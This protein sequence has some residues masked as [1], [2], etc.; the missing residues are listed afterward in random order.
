MARIAALAL[1]L[2][3]A[4]T[5]CTGSLWSSARRPDM[6]YRV[7][8]KTTTAVIPP[9][10]LVYQDVHAPLYPMF[11]ASLPTRI[12]SKKGTS[13]SNLIG[14]P[15]L[16]Y[17]GLATGLD[18]FAWGDASIEDARRNGGI[19]EVEYVDVRMQMYV[20]VFRRFTIEAYGD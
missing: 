11:G 20:F 6:P 4:G 10:G 9:P 16:P 5:G 7:L 19:D 3:V 2:A 18:L 17:P 13:T 15:P 1:L 8:S 14:L 12:G